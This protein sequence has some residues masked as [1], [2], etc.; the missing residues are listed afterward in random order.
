MMSLQNVSASW[1]PELIKHHISYME[2][3]ITKEHYII[4][5]F[6]N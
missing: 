4:E 3:F 6:E 2:S 1:K 5:V